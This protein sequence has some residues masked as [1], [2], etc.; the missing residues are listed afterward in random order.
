MKRL[1]ELSDRADLARVLNIPLHSLTYVLYIKK[2][3]NC[4]SSFEIPKKSG[5]VRTINKPSDELKSI[6]RRL[7]DYLYRLQLEMWKE[8]KT[9]P[10]IS[11][12]F[13]KKR[14]NKTNARIHKRKRYVL[15]VDLADYFDSFHFGRVRGFFIRSNDFQ[16]NEKIATLIAQIACYNAKLPQGAPTSPIIS[17]LIFQIVDR[18]ILKL[19]RE[20]GLDYTRYADDL[21]FS[22]NKKDFKEHYEQ[23]LKD[24]SEV[25]LHSGFQ[26]NSKKTRLVDYHSRQ[27]V[28]GLVVNQR[29]GINDNY[30]K[31]VRAMAHSLYKTGEFSIDGESGTIEQLSGMFSYID[32][33][34]QYN[35]GQPLEIDD[36]HFRKLNR[37]EKEYRRFCFYKTFYANEKPLILTEGKTDIIYLSCALM[38]YWN[39]YPTLIERLPDGSYR[40][41][42]AFFHRTRTI[43]KLFGIV[44]GGADTVKNFYLN[45]YKKKEKSGEFPDYYSYFL[46]L[47]GRK[48]KKPVVVVFDNELEKKKG[49]KQPLAVFMENIEG[50]KEQ[51]KNMIKQQYW[52][53][54]NRER[55]LFIVTHPINSEMQNAEIEDLFD[56]D[57]L[58]HEINGKTFCRGKE[59]EF[60]KEKHYSKDHFSKYIASSYS[61]ISFEGFVPFLDTINYVIEEYLK[62]N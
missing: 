10:L 13:Q 54:P 35:S 2:T 58:A 21:T 1:A 43:Q 24:L 20:Y 45:F 7:A 6:Q 52:V 32:S 33:I 22:T 11:H 42:V 61:E 34:V 40:F 28:T 62:S 37:F 49:K 36:K 46:E 5:G 60:N 57:T 53:Q 48:P 23:F 56:A 44:P 31:M 47:S 15:N 41:K 18:R 39:R 3:E 59:E 30:H 38:K 16:C 12:A 50:D 8:K 29:I 19:T 25:M 26:I 4:Y 27:T 14:S 55:N 17:N 51:Q 9:T